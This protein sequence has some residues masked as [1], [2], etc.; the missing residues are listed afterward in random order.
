MSVT[1]ELLAGS[2]DMHIHTGPDPRVE[3]K[4]NALEAALQAKAVGMRAIVIK[5]HEYPTA[6]VAYTV[7]Q[8]VKGIT[9]FGSITLN[10][11]VGGLNTYTVEAS[12]KLGAKVVWMP[13]N[14][15][16]NDMKKK[17]IDGKGITILDSE[18]MLVPSVKDILA[19][20]KKYE[21]VLS[22]GHLSKSEV[23]ALVDEAERMSINKIVI[24]HPLTEVVGANL[25]LQDQRLMVQKG[26]FIENAWNVT[27]SPREKLD[28]MRIVEAVRAVGAEH[29][30]LT[31]DFGQPHNLLPVEGMRTMIATMLKCGIS[32]GEVELMVKIN[33]AKLLNMD[34]P[35]SRHLGRDDTVIGFP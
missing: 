4:L 34:D 16:E 20:I 17:N 9:V 32:Q 18:G 33:P 6:P 5:S 3:R 29:C 10:L 26:A 12:A 35:G 15:S 23:F 22:T 19:I 1:D 14:H 24:T 27:S 8:V 28:P 31:T 30:I 21:M 13:T 7:N 25:N 11:E 2:I